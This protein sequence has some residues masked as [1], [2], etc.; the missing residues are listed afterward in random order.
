M[1]QTGFQRQRSPFSHFDHHIQPAVEPQGDVDVLPQSTGSP[2]MFRLSSD[3]SINEEEMMIIESDSRNVAEFVMYLSLILTSPQ[4]KN[5]ETLSISGKEEL[6]VQDCSGFPL[7]HVFYLSYL[8]P[9]ELC[10]ILNGFNSRL[11]LTFD[12]I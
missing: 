11:L 10:H 2:P 3:T 6:G 4:G 7:S 1:N 8:E 5:L 9:M 12:V